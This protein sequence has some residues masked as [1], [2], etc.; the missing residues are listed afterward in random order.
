[1]LW[2]GFFEIDFCYGGLK[3]KYGFICDGVVFIL[4]L[5]HESW[6]WVFVIEA[7]K[8]NV[9]WWFDKEWGCW[10]GFLTMPFFFFSKFRDVNWNWA[11]YRRYNLH[12]CPNK[13]K[14]HKKKTKENVSEVKATIIFIFT[15][16]ILLLASIQIFFHDCNDAI[17]P[18]K[19][20]LGGFLIF[21]ACSKP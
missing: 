15:A 12:F 2:F 11:K 5:R 20:N 16:Y 1:M 10:N 18:L 4:L 6:K 13:N 9:W 19:I 7:W 14:K 21:V 17:E 8:L 3:V